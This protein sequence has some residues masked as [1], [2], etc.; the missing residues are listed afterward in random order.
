MNDLEKT[1]IEK[2][3]TRT[4]PSE[5]IGK[6]MQDAARANLIEAK[7]I[8][9]MSPMK[10]S[11]LHEHISRLRRNFLIGD[12]DKF[13]FDIQDEEPYKESNRIMF[14]RHK[15]SEGK[16]SDDNCDGVFFENSKEMPC[17]KDT[18]ES[19]SSSGREVMDKVLKAYFEYEKRRTVRKRPYLFYLGIS[20]TIFTLVFGILLYTPTPY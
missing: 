13:H 7:D 2:Y 4:I 19:N 5:D 9:P 3:G 20:A 18:H 12:D 17:F 8:K 16:F 1:L 6:I 10:A 11:E 15:A 14:G